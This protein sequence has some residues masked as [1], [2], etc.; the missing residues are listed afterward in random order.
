MAGRDEGYSTYQY[1]P[2]GASPLLREAGL[3]WEE[4]DFMWRLADGWKRSTV[5]SQRHVSFFEAEAGQRLESS[6]WI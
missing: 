4:C 5:Y 1:N 2:E 3:S 6:L